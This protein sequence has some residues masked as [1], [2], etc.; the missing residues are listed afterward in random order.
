MIMKKLRI[1]L[2]NILKENA[3]DILFNQYVFINIKKI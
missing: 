1:L 3:I 2:K